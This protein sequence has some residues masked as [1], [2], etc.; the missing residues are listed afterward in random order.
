MNKGTNTAE[1]LTL[2]ELVTEIKGLII[3]SALAKI[4]IGELL[5][6]HTE[7]I[8]DAEKDAFYKNI[9]MSPR[10]AQYYMKIASNSLVQEL[11]REN[12]LERL[13]MLAT[14]D[15]ILM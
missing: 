14:F 10:T 13:N 2:E 15:L 6:E 8:P 5:N 9:A 1:R 11:E 3:R 4:K 7:Y 12:K